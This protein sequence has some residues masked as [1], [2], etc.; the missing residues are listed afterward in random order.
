MIAA[1]KRRFKQESLQVSLGEREEVSKELIAAQKVGYRNEILKAHRN[2]KIKDGNY[3]QGPRVRI[4]GGALKNDIKMDRTLYLKRQAAG[5]GIPSGSIMAHEKN[6]NMAV[7]TLFAA[8][9]SQ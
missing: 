4:P 6:W 7:S 1:A 9:F 3:N 2:K 8:S 5:G